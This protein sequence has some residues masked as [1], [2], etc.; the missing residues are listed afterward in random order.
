MKSKTT[1]TIYNRLS[2]NLLLTGCLRRPTVLRFPTRDH[3]HRQRE[4]RGFSS[5]LYF[6]VANL[7]T[8]LLH[9][10]ADLAAQAAFL[11]SNA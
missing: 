8:P 7:W 3:V 2:A 11:T 1:P 6:T 10:T 9:R 4:T 5:A